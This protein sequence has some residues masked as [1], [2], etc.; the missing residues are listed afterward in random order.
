MQLDLRTVSIRPKR[1]TFSHI[2]RR[3]GADKPASRYQEGT[4][5]LQV[6]HNFHYRPYWAPQFEL[7]DVR[8]TAIQMADW[9]TFKDPRQFYYGTY[10][11]ARARQQETTEGAFSFVEERGLVPNLPATV[12][13]QALAVLLPLR[14]LEWG[15][16]MNNDFICAYGYGTA[17]TQ[18]A[19]FH[20]MDR[21]GIAQYLTRIGLT[22]G[23]PDDL[24][25]AKQAWLDAPAWQGLRRY[26]EDTFVLEDWFELFVAQNMVLD[27][28]LYPLAYQHFDVALTQQGGTAVS[29][30][31]QFMRDWK[32]E[33]DKWLDATL[34]TAAAE[35]PANAA[36]LHAW[37]SKWEA[38]ALEALTP[39]ATLAL[40]EAGGAALN[41]VHSQWRGRL[42][43][44]G[45]APQGAAA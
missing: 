6:T 32:A 20:A 38:R 29:M 23:S 12:R 9:Y 39:F 25:A 10:T 24:D 44:L 2:A 28:L 17:V 4:L 1:Q 30:L 19:L 41:E 31:T 40:G 36:Q 5:D 16:N 34:K 8:R 13:K 45:V 27:G 26:V 18:P 22:L 21:L 7:F 43:K 14:H 11:L 35:S 37:V 3:L 15:A 42:T 33:S